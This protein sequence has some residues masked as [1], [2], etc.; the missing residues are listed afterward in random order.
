MDVHPLQIGVEFYALR[1]RRN[2]TFAPKSWESN[3][4]KITSREAPVPLPQHPVR[5]LDPLFGT[6]KDLLAAYPPDHERQLQKRSP[7]WNRFRTHTGIHF[8][9]LSV[10]TIPSSPTTEWFNFWRSANKINMWIPLS[11]F[12]TN[13][14]KGFLSKKYSSETRSDPGIIQS[15]PL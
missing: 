15:F 12:L 10:L 14:S 3:K 9:Y 1:T 2:A 13:I 8:L 11:L 7:I 4:R 6:C 5:E